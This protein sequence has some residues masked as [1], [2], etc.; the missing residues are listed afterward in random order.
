MAPLE[1]WEKVLI[2]A[3]AFVQ[4]THGRMDCI[5]CHGGVQSPDKETAHQGLIARPSEDSET[6]C[7]ECHPNVVPAY[8]SSLHLTQSG[9]WTVLDERSA[10]E[11][12]PA[13]EEMFGNHCSSCHTTCGDCHV[14]QPSSVGGGFVSGHIFQAKPSMTRNCT[15]CHGSRVGKE[16]LGKN[17]GVRADVHFRQA[18]MTCVD[19]H[20][21]DEMHAN[22]RKD[23][24]SCHSP[25]ELFGNPPSPHRYH[26]E[27]QPACTDCHS[28]VVNGLDG[29]EMHKQ[30]SQDLS[31]QV[32]HSVEYTSCDSCHVAVSEDTGNP[33]FETKASYLTF[34]IG[35]N[36]L[37]SEARPYEY[38]VLRH[39]PVD[40]DSFSYYGDNLLPN[41]DALPTWVYA[42]PHNIQLDTPQTETCNACHGNASLFLTADKVNPAEMEAN[43][44]VIVESVPEPV[45]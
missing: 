31:C 20:T 24:A 36:P 33:Y 34:L 42:T 35:R 41:Y 22:Q 11:N 17:E 4:T 13:L 15:A 6:F 23:C 27:E 32:C 25:S 14:S 2:D 3:G 12:H 10:P 9:Y 26:G 21:M 43:A 38:V 30:H 19:C 16:Y 7:G 39:V 1:P 45:P 8:Q 37:Q 18:R 40:K 29:V 44:P 5:E 28:K